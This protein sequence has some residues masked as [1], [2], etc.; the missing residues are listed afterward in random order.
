MRTALL[1]ALVL[2]ACL[3]RPAAA[4]SEPRSAERPAGAA[5]GLPWWMLLGGALVLGA[6]GGGAVAL[7]VNRARNPPLDTRDRAPAQGPPVPPIAARDETA[8]SV[9]RLERRVAQLEQASEALRVEVQGL[10]AAPPRP[11][12]PR[13]APPPAP[14]RTDVPVSERVA[15]AFVS[16]CRRGGPMVS[17]LDRFRAAL[18]P[19]VP[20]ATVQQV[21]RDLNAQAE[22]TRFDAAG[23][24]SPA[25]YWVV[26]VG[27][28]RLLLPHPQSPGQFR[29]LAGVFAGPGVPPSSVAQI[30]PARVREE[31]A[32]FV[33]TAEGR[34]A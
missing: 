14:V 34:L 11:A 5:S 20:E 24:A 29:D 23:G 22:P 18:E 1:L 30:D 28:E 19:A 10:R 26:A 9:E 3:A 7:L 25:E 33:L 32:A 31:G 15:E 16:W 8:E 6:V 21:F 27:E 4:Q 13:P 2:G 17:R 12:P